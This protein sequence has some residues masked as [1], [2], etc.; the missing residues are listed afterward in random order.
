MLK[1]ANQPLLST[2]YK[3]GDYLLA[4]ADLGEEKAMTARFSFGGTEKGVL[5]A[6]QK[7]GSG[8]F[9]LD[10]FDKSVEM[11]LKNAKMLRKLLKG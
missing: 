3:V 1:M 5:T 7:G 9:T 4:D 8:S 6:F 11:G 2:T 10:E